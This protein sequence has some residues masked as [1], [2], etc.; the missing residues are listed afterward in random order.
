M[1]TFTSMYPVVK[2]N[3]FH[4]CSMPLR[5]L[6]FAIGVSS[7]VITSFPSSVAIAYYSRRCNPESVRILNRF[8]NENVSGYLI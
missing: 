2:Q 1:L 6:K 3:L 8:W 4:D 7:I 5:K